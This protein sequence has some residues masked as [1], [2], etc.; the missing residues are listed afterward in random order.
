MPAPIQVWTWPTPNGH[1]VHILLEELA[2]AGAGIPYE[3]VPVA[4]G[5][6]EQFRPEFLA[7]TPNH[8]IPAIV[9]PEGPGGERFSLF[10]SG[11]IL[12][13]LAEK[14]GSDLWPR[15]PAT[16]YRCL[17]WVMF[18]MGGV[19]PMFGQ[20]NHFANYAVEKLPYAIERYTNE[21]ARLHRVLDKRLAESPYLA[22]PGYSIADIA[23]FPWVRNPE[24]RNVDLGQYPH[25]KR[26]HDAIAA[27]PAVRRGV[28]VLAE[29]QR[30]GQMTDAEREQLF[31][32]TQF[33]A[34]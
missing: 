7:I 6:G 34:H 20:Y 10:E 5:K 22:G 8:R 29:S 16:R 9:D 14:A 19:G 32:K 23:T 3:I 26:W 18:Q 31:G 13:Y 12:I 28:S 24:R 21:V 25:V 11:A 1:K 30:K 4:I 27:R 17:Q 33:A 2:E 15:D